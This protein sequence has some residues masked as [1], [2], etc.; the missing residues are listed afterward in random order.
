MV[1]AQDHLVVRCDIIKEREDVD[2]LLKEC[3]HLIVVR[4]AGDGEHRSMV[5]LGIIQTVEKMN[6][7][8][9]AVA[10]QTPSLPV[11]LA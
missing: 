6:R 10:K 3:S 4:L 2:L 7:A 1:R 5:E 9:P 8:G 11:N